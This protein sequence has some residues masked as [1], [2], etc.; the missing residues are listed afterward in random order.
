MAQTNPAISC[1]RLTVVVPCHNEEEVL[2]E[3]VL[4]LSNLLDALS[5]ASLIAEPSIYFVDDGSTDDTWHAIERLAAKDARV[6][7]LSLIHI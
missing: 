4:R 6:H 5:R 1:P 7:G 2:S 3:T